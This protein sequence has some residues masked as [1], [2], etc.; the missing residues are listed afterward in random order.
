MTSSRCT[1]FLCRICFRMETSLSKLCFS[2][3]FSLSVEISLIATTLPVS[4][5][6]AFHTTAKEPDP[7]FC[8]NTQLATVLKLES[9]ITASRRSVLKN[10]LLRP[11]PQIEAVSQTSAT[12]SARGQGVTRW[13]RL[14]TWCKGGSLRGCLKNCRP[15]HDP[16]RTAEL[17][18]WSS[19]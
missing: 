4:L 6:A 7:A 10:K 19:S 8:C 15:H 3:L 12:Q 18:S 1:M 9:P 16:L 17:F 5:C 13:L 2:F 11:Q 14:L